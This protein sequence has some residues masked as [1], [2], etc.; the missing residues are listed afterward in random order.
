MIPCWA[1]RAGPLV[2]RGLPW[3]NLRSAHFSNS[4]RGEEQVPRPWDSILDYVEGE[5]VYG[6]L[7][8]CSYR[9]AASQPNHGLAALVH[10]LL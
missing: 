8:V 9:E 10:P 2:R 4:D 7:F 5:G 3:R 1:A 6:C